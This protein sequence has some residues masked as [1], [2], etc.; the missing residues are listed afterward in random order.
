M[1]ETD[2]VAPELVARG[3]KFYQDKL[4]A[5]LEPSQTGQF[6][7]LEPDTEQYFV[8]ADAV[9]ALL[10]GRAKMPDKLFFLVRIGYPTAHKMG[11]YAKRN[12]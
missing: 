4:K 3:K 6:V 12:G 8:A 1:V 7:A 2:T 11:G 10:A 9:D 5:L